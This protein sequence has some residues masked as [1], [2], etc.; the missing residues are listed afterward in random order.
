MFE[1]CHDESFFFAI[2][3]RLFAISFSFVVL[4]FVGIPNAFK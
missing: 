2:P 4:R 3:Q 1:F